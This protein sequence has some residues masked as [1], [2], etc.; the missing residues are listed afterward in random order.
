MQLKRIEDFQL[1]ELKNQKVFINK[2]DLSLKYDYELSI[3][4]K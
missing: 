2:Y 3:Y 1:E 4:W